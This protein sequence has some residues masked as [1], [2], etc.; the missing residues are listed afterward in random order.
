M[1]KWPWHC[2]WKFE[3]RSSFSSI[4]NN[5]ADALTCTLTHTA[6]LLY[7]FGNK[8]ARGITTTTTTTTEICQSQRKVYNPILTVGSAPAV[9][10]CFWL[11]RY[12][13]WSLILC[14]KCELF[15]YYFLRNDLFLLSILI[16]FSENQKK[17][18]LPPGKYSYPFQF[19]LPPNLPSSFEG[20]HGYIR[21]WVKA[22]IE[23]P[24]SYEHVTKTAFSVIS[25]LDLNSLPDASVSLRVVSTFIKILLN[26]F[27]MNKILSILF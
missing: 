19:Q 14:D 18:I 24:W 7:P 15:T 4:P 10:K 25:A 17:I 6:A 5:G 11:Y 9:K 3:S 27:D 22:T 26:F 13:Y 21:Y 8:V 16:F 2:R 23:K 1:Q 12:L 20:Q